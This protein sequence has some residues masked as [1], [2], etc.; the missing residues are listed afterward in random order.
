ML[1]VMCCYEISLLL[2]ATGIFVRMLN[3]RE[4]KEVWRNSWMAPGLKW[5]TRY[6]HLLYTIKSTLRW[7]KFEQNW[8]DCHFSS[9]MQGMCHIQNSWRM[10]W[11]KKKMF[12][13]FTRVRNWLWHSGSSTELLV[14]HCKKWKIFG[15]VK[16]ATLP[17]S[18]F[19][20]SWET[21]HGQGCWSLSSL[22]SM[23]FLLAWSFGDAIS[24]SCQPLW[25]KFILF[26][27]CLVVSLWCYS[28]T[29]LSAFH[30]FCTLYFLHGLL[31]MP[32]VCHI[33]H[34]KES[35]FCL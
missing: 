19:Q 27:A 5:T 14:L 2:L 20:N 11:K 8:T 35:T 12:L 24:L 6:I 3:S 10:M 33:N 7:L 26:V 21:N 13:S 9:M 15:F 34:Y 22:F 4:R 17:Q 28:W 29:P 30:H 18:L 25:R 1:L 23:V 31:V 16:T 32:S